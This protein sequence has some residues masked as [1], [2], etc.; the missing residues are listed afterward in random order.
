MSKLHY[1][2]G[3]RKVSTKSKKQLFADLT[4]SDNEPSWVQE[5]SEEEDDDEEELKV[6]MIDD[7]QMWNAGIRMFIDALETVY[8]WP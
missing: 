6:T 2:T 5:I 4:M 3:N 8:I 1:G 7:D